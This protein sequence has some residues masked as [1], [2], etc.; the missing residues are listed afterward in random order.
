MRSKPGSASKAVLAMDADAELSE[1]SDVAA[2][3]ARRAP[4]ASALDDVVEDAGRQRLAAYYLY[5][6][7][8]SGL[9]ADGGLEP[10]GW[11]RELA[12]RMDDLGLRRFAPR[13]ERGFDTELTPPEQ[14]TRRSSGKEFQF[15]QLAADLINHGAFGPVCGD[16]D[17]VRVVEA[18]D[19]R[20]YD[21]ELLAGE[22][23]VGRCRAEDHW[24]QVA[25]QL[26]SAPHGDD[27]LADPESGQAFAK[28]TGRWLKEHGIST[29]ISKTTDLAAGIYPLGTAVG[30]GTR[31]LRSR[32]QTGPQEA[33]AL[34]R[35]S[36]V[37]S[38]IRA[39]AD[40]EAS[41][42]NLQV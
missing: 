29:G 17:R 6:V 38:R 42:R 2:D 19:H 10:E 9:V 30:V 34:L 23:V 16:A 1:L 40:G 31:L 4:G 26:A 18:S 24:E 25:Q 21:F 36:Q 5:S 37:L 39:E 14:A 33:D 12:E 20:G 13:T 7:L 28:K 32:I 3:A 27:P 11:P 22:N 41:R 15:A 35:L 8:I